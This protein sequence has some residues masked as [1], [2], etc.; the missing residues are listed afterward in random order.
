MIKRFQIRIYTERQL[1]NRQMLLQLLLLIVI[2]NLHSPNILQRGSKLWE[3]LFTILNPE[4]SVSFCFIFIALETKACSLQR[5]S[6]WNWCLVHLIVP[7]FEC[8][9]DIVDSWVWF[10]DWF[11]SGF[12]IIDIPGSKTVE[13]RG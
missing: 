8:S 4:L 3:S 7:S 6:D 1:P 9:K 2:L 13:D 12:F 5:L 11:C 10:S